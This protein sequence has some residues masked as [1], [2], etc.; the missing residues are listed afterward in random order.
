MQFT[1][2][3]LVSCLIVKRACATFRQLGEKAAQRRQAQL[4]AAMHAAVGGPAK[5]NMR[6]YSVAYGFV[7]CSYAPDVQSQND[8]QKVVVKL[9]R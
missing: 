1:R 2:V 5:M 7:A 3:Q 6:V 9:S 8:D 4:L